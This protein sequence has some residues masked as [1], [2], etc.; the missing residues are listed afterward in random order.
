M[1]RD[2]D[3]GEVGDLEC[4][5]LETRNK[6]RGHGELGD[7]NWRRDAIHP[8]LADALGAELAHRIF[9]ENTAPDDLEEALLNRWFKIHSCVVDGRVQHSAHIELLFRVGG[10]ELGEFG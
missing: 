9:F 4:R 5:S 3:A 10:Q 7:L 8:K 2:V 6:E 1:H